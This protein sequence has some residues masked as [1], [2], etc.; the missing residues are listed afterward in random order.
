MRVF[1]CLCVYVCPLPSEIYIFPL[2][3]QWTLRDDWLFLFADP[4]LKSSRQHHCSLWRLN[5]PQSSF[6]P[7]RSAFPDVKHHCDLL[8]LLWKNICNQKESERAWGEIAQKKNMPAILFSNVLCKQ[9]GEISFSIYLSHP[10]M[11][12]LDFFSVQILLPYQFFVTYFIEEWLKKWD[13][14]AVV[15]ACL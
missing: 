10:N 2:M 8:W 3:S 7:N 13:F 1:V 14:C 6:N 5:P 11:S 4:T 15:K 12:H 9:N